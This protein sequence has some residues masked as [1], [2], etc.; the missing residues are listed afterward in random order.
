MDM[1]HR[2]GNREDMFPPM[3]TPIPIMK[4]DNKRFRPKQ[5]SLLPFLASSLS[6]FSGYTQHRTLDEISS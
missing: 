3:A 4:G 5:S 1:P 2:N 6:Q